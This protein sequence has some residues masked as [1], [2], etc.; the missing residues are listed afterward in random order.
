MP[1]LYIVRGLIAPYV[2]END[3]YFIDQQGNYNWSADKVKEAAA[4]CHGLVEGL[5]RA[6]I[7][8]IAVCNT[9]TRPWE[10]EKYIKLAKVHEYNIKVKVMNNLWSWSVDACYKL[11]SHNVPKQVIES[12]KDRWEDY[13]GEQF[14]NA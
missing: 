6:K 1:T 13:E 8:D 2:C 12:M 7:N 4:Y 10:F 5:M 14:V 11:N 3:Q 9:H